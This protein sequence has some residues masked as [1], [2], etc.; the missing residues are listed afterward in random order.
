MTT[1]PGTGTGSRHR[2]VSQVSSYAQCGE[3]YRLSRVAM[4]PSKPAAWFPHGT[5]YHAVIEEYENSHRQI[6]NPALEL[7]LIHI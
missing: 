4:A 2:S 1:E 7:S 6:S 3:A 5:A